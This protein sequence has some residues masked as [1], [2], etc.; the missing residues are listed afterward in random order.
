MAAM[1][2]FSKTPSRCSQAEVC[3]CVRINLVDDAAII[4]V[5]SALVCLRVLLLSL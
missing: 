1:F 4:L 3:S 5:V 2:H